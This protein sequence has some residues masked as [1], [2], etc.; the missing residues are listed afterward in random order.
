MTTYYCV[1]FSRNFSADDRKHLSDIGVIIMERL[2]ADDTYLVRVTDEKLARSDPLISV[3]YPFVQRNREYDLD[4]GNTFDIIL[5][6]KID[7]KAVSDGLDAKG[8]SVT[9]KRDQKIRIELVLPEQADVLDSLQ[10]DH[11][12]RVVEQYITPRFF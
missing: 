3:M 1:N 2:D 8:V 10:T 9:Y 11:R 5:H 12:I 4:A 7:L 6:D